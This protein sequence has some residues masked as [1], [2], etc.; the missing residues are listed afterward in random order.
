MCSR[1]CLSSAPSGSSI[2]TSCGSNT[3]ARASATRCCW[4]P[5]S[6]AGKRSPCPAAHHV[7][8]RATLA[9][10]SLFEHLAHRQR[11]GHV[12][13]DRQ[14]RE[15]RVVL[16]HH[17]EVALVRRR[18]RDRLAVEQ[19]LAGG[20]RLEA[21]QHHQR[22]RLARARRAQ[23]GQELAAPDVQVELAHDQLNAVVRLLDAD[24]AHQRL[25]T[26]GHAA[27]PGA[28]DAAGSAARSVMDG[29]GV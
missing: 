16:E 1:S 8:R 6:C 5:E 14:V 27:R 10:C 24:E 22:R 23:Q 26:V 9:A 2:S 20:R 19:D 4:P 3:S 21:G 15:Q 13:P 25:G 28:G 29:A 11:V 7:E 17:A 18:A 12:L